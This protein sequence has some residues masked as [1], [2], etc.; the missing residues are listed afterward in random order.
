VAATDYRTEMS[1]SPEILSR[2]TDAYRRIRNTARYLLGNLADFQAGQALAPEQMLALDRYALHRAQHLQEEIL[3]AYEGYNFHIVAQRVH[4][5]CAVELGAFYLDVLKDRLYTTRADS[6][7]RRSAQTAMHHVTEALVRWLAPILSFTAE[8]I[9]RHMPGARAESVFLAE[10]YSGWPEARLGETGM[11]EVFWDDVLR[12]RGEVSKRLERLRAAGEIGSGLEAEV[13]LY[14]E[15]NTETKLRRFG[16]ELKFVFITS[17]A[18]V[19]PLAARPEQAVETGLSGVW[20]HVVPAPKRKCV[21]CW[22]RRADVG[23]DAAH[24]ELCP[25]CV[26]NVAGAG[27]VRRFA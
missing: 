8:E 1:V 4:E 12:V 24:P 20:L 3:R 14:C 9:W 16:D 13:N 7:A 21:R 2:A 5:Y 25:R 27:E 17:A 22:H 26:E 19:H 23:S 15:G 6:T 11:D 10:W 18:A